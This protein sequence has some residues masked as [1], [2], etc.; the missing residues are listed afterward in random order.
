ML[1]TLIQ[2]GFTG[3]H[4]ALVSVWKDYDLEGFITIYPRIA[5]GLIVAIIALG[6]IDLLRGKI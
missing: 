5:G 6:A 4:L 1:T 2:V 3:G